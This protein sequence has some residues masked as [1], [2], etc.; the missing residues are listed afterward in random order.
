MNKES[1]NNY[2]SFFLS[3]RHSTEHKI[4]TNF[5]ILYFLQNKKLPLY[6]MRDQYVYIKVKTHRRQKKM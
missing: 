6:K 2:F 3:V 1:T 5:A 4:R